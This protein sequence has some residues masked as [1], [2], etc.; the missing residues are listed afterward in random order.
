MARVGL[1]AAMLSWS[2][3]QSHMFAGTGSAGGDALGMIAYDGCCCGYTAIGSSRSSPWNCELYE[4][5]EGLDVL[6]DTFE[7]W[8]IRSQLV[9]GVKFRRCSTAWG[10]MLQFDYWLLCLVFLTATLLT[11]PRKQSQQEPDE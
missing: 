4:V 7:F 1:V 10:Y 3:T 11:W 2:V 6:T 8:P 5:A 9:P